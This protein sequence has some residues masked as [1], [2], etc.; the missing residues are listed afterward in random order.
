M[1]MYIVKP[2]SD[3]LGRLL[4][5]YIVNYITPSELWGDMFALLHVNSTR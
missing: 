3:N 2:D 1:Y 4:A 5:S